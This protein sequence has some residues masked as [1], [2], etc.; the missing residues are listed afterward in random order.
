MKLFK[1]AG[2]ALAA[3]ALS[4][5][6]AAAAP[7]HDHG[8]AEG[9]G[10]AVGKGPIGVL[11]ADHG[12]PPD[13]NATTY[14]SFREFIAHLMEMEVIPP[15]LGAID[16]GTI[17]QDP[18]CHGCDAL[19]ST[20]PFLNAW[21]Q[22]HDLPAAWAPS[23][24]EDLAAYRFVPGGRGQGEPD[25]FEHGGLQTRNEWELMGGTSPNYAQKLAKK[26]IVIK[27]LK[28]R[29]G[30]RIA[31]SVGYGIDPR[32]G[33]GV[34]DIHAAT[35]R[36]MD[37]GVRRIVAVYHGVGF[38][39][40]MQTHMIRHRIEHTLHNHG[41]SIPVT[42]APQ[43]GMT[44]PYVRSVVAEVRAE[45]ARLP[46]RAPVAVHLSGHGIPTT[47]CGG[48][49]C[50]LDSYHSHSRALFARV[51]AAVRKAVRK[52]PGRVGVF[53]LYGDGATDEDDPG[54]LVHSPI[55]ALDA[56]AAAGFR[57][58]IDVPY[59]FDSDSRD[60]LIV[61]RQGY[62]RPIPDWDRRYESRFEY[63]GMA[64]KIGNASF[65]KRLKARALERV[66]VRGIGAA[67]RLP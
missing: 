29:Y 6:A 4:A 21:E 43:M 23:P 57:H 63:A 49:P 25:I 7:E 48:Y 10:P 39:E 67:R 11:I 44:R 47:E 15:A 51:S 62:K 5:P 58:V 64:V 66:A 16:T 22:G 27:R 26:R 56:R 36:L 31:I 9:G 40:M 33:G 60:T 14:E 53:N 12:E 55:E 8:G 45:L 18:D 30:K 46:K 50:G 35:H 41:S 17:L 42:Y 61:L 59:E 2:A 32:I 34:Q 54:E 37:R 19:G 20:A 28:R 1:G 13:Y 65:G 3:L 24:S 52:R 38:S